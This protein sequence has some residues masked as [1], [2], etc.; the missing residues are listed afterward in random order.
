MVAIEGLP[1]SALEIAERRI[2]RGEVPEVDLRFLLT[3]PELAKLCREI[4]AEQRWAGTKPQ[5]LS[6]ERFDAPPDPAVVKKL[7]KVLGDLTKVVD[8]ERHETKRD[9]LKRMGSR[10][11]LYDAAS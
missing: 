10:V 1:L 6:L 5:M 4:V 3:P 9:W 2:V 8:I 7:D 11:T